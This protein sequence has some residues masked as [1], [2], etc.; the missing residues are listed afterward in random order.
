MKMKVSDYIINFLKEK[1]IC[2]MFFLPGGGCMHLLNSLAENAGMEGISLLHEQAAAIAA[3]SYSFCKG[4]PGALLVTTG[5]GGTNAVTGVLSAYIDSIPYFVLSGQVKTTDLKSQYGVRA[6]GSQEAD[7]ISMVKDIT[8]YAVMVTKPEEI[9]YHLERAWHE[10]THGRKGPVWLD[11]PL[12]VQGDSVD[13]EK[14]QSFTPQITTA[15]T[16]EASIQKTV[17]LLQNAK[18]PVLMIGNGV[19]AC[20]EKL[21]QLLDKLQ[22]PV[23]PSW[24]GVDLLENDH[25]LYIGRCGNLGERTA[26]FAMQKA[27]FI[28]SLGCRLDYS[29][30]GYN[31]TQWAPQAVKVVVEIDPSELEKL[32]DA[33][34]SLSV[35]EDVNSFVDRLLEVPF[36]PPNLTE[37]REKIHHWQKKYPVTHGKTASSPNGMLTTYD[38]MDILC[39]NAPD[40]AVFVP[41]SAGTVAEIFHQAVKVKKGQTIRSNHGLGSM[42]YEIPASIGAFYATERPVICVAGDG[43][44]QLNIQELAVIAGR[45]LP[46]KIF[47]VNNNGYSS[48]RGMQRTHFMGSYFGSSRETGLFLP[49]MLALA[50]AYGIAGQRVVTSAELKDC[51]KQALAANGPF[52]CDVIIDPM[53]VVSPKAASRVLE[54][55]KMISTSLEDLYPFLPQ[56]ELM[57]ELNF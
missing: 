16:N 26:N 7:I 6:L 54:D 40:E 15:S 12:D 52:I 21:Y 17:S 27:D 14:L 43:G 1:G 11:I 9:R 4:Q 19:R 55:G 22:I 38:F 18:R 41:A 35:C 37:W 25:P 3:E 2:H 45:R 10:M 32:H 30:T 50:S 44:M 5:P 8:K 20:G 34:I 23:I 24:K 29:I 48:I 33:N 51:V 31:R 42:G 53:C 13:P 39:E 49:D 46:V 47:V 57:E 28:L 56:E 36:T